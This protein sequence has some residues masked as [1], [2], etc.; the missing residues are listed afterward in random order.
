MSQQFG[1]YADLTVMENIDFYADLYEVPKAERP[2][3]PGALCTPSPIWVPSG[4]ACGK[5]V[6]GMKQKLS[7]LRPHPPPQGPSAGRAHL[8]GGSHLPTGPLAH[9]PRDGGGR[10]HRDG[11]RPY[12]DEAERCDRVI[13]LDQGRISGPGHPEELAAPRPPPG[14]GGGRQLGPAPARRS[15]MGEGSPRGHGSRSLRQ[16]GS[17]VTVGWRTGRGDREALAGRLESGG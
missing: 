17:R 13:L 10:G 15:V 14:G 4:P 7:L 2:A 16:Q 12:M 5:P 1:L 6:R 3:A 8:R 11:C 9:P